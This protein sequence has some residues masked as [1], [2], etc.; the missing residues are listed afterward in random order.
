MSGRWEQET[1]Q[2]PRKTWG[3]K[4]GSGGASFIVQ[5]ARPQVFGS[6]KPRVSEISQEGCQPSRVEWPRGLDT[7]VWPSQ[8]EQAESLGIRGGSSIHL[9]VEGEVGA[10]VGWG[11]GHP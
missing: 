5:G 3:A 7:V 11:T 1:S 9:N 10:G 2:R 4:R 8:G 6:Q